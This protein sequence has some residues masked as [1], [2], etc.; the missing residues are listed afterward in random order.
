MARSTSGI[1]RMLKIS[2]YFLIN[3][4]FAV[5]S[6]KKKNNG[7]L[8][9]NYFGYLFECHLLTYC[10]I[11]GFLKEWFYFMIS[12]SILFVVRTQLN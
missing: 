4:T 11:F 10:T 2:I 1:D 7:D 8:T 12:I 5:V 9:N 3:L 6:K